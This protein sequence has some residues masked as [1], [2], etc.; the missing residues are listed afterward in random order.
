MPS[1]IR[2]SR[3][4]TAAC[5]LAMALSVA[6]VHAQVGAAELTGM[7]RDQAGAALSN[8]SITATDVNRRVSHTVLSSSAGVYVVAGLMPGEYQIRAELLGFRP[9][10]RSGLRLTTGEAT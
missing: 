10:V 4:V 5:G 2:G 7:V 8:A 9:L 3:A 6:R 1:G